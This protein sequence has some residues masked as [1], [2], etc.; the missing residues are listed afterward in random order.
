MDQV[1]IQ[2][3]LESK[4]QEAIQG[5]LGQLDPMDLMDFQEISKLLKSIQ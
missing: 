1:E 3:P 5:H 2:D 4:D